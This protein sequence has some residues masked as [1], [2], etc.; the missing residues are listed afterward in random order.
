[1]TTSLLK[2]SVNP[3]ESTPDDDSMRFQWT[4]G[5]GVGDL[6]APQLP[7]AP[8]HA[9]LASWVHGHLVASEPSQPW[10][11]VAAATAGTPVAPP[12]V[13][14][15]RHVLL[16]PPGRGDGLI[17]LFAGLVLLGL[18]IIGAITLGAW[19]SEPAQ[20][21][22]VQQPAPQQQTWVEQP[23]AYVP[24]TDPAAGAV[25]PTAAQGSGIAPD[26][27]GSAPAGQQPADGAAASGAT[28]SR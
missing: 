2:A 11:R 25:D 26:V 20:A 9:D 12:M 24:A 10:H 21:K 16:R 19:K 8:Q 4:A 23:A 14:T 3:W 13:T 1:M 18:P 28:A 5:N 15:E 27:T 6:A 7:H 17:G 22:A